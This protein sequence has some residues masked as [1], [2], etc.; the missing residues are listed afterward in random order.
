MHRLMLLGLLH[1]FQ[2]K[3]AK[4]QTLLRREHSQ[5]QNRQDQAMQRQASGF[6][7]GMGKGTSVSNSGTQKYEDDRK[8]LM[9]SLRDLVVTT[10]ETQDS[11]AEIAKRQ[12]D[13]YEGTCIS[14]QVVHDMNKTLDK[15]AGELQ[16]VNIHYDS[17]TTTQANDINVLKAKVKVPDPPKFKGPPQQYTFWIHAIECW[18]EAGRVT[19]GE[20]VIY[21]QGHLEGEP[22]NIGYLL[23]L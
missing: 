5:G 10:K 17:A 7:H 3:K 13:A 22:L 8:F 21:A 12:Q 4:Q 16:N 1:K 20:K 18:L 11:L 9:G 15:L 19:E 14:E 2:G 6:P 23:H